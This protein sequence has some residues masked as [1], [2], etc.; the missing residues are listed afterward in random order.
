LFFLVWAQGRDTA[1]QTWKLRMSVE[2]HTVLGKEEEVNIFLGSVKEIDNP[3]GHEGIF[4][5]SFT[6]LRR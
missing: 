5:V 1:E 3:K 2:Q 6:C 4:R